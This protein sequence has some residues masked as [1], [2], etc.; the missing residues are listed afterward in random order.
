MKFISILVSINQI[1]ETQGTRGKKLYRKGKNT[2][3]REQG[4]W[5]HCI[6]TAVNDID[7]FAA[8]FCTNLTYTIS[9]VISNYSN[10]DI[11]DGTVSV[12]TI[13]YFCGLGESSR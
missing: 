5:S 12:M 7:L 3:R 8:L 10:S 9:A 6:K 13:S 2:E 4:L 1:L 11:L